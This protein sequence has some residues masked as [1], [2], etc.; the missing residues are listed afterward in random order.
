MAFPL[1]LRTCYAR[2]SFGRTGRLV[3]EGFTLVWLQR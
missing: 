3:W 2:S 1:S